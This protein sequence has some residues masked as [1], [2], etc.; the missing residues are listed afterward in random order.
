MGLENSGKKIEKQYIVTDYPYPHLNSS[1]QV[2]LSCI[3]VGCL[4]YF[5]ITLSNPP[6]YCSHLIM[7]TNNMDEGKNDF[8]QH[9]EELYIDHL[10][11]EGLSMHG[12]SCGYDNESFPLPSVAVHSGRSFQPSIVH[13][14]SSPSQQFPSSSIGIASGAV[15]GNIVDMIHSQ[16]QDIDGNIQH[17]VGGLLFEHIKHYPQR[18]NLLRATSGE[19]DRSGSNAGAGVGTGGTSTPTVSNITFSNPGSRSS[20][21][22]STPTGIMRQR[23]GSL[24][25]SA[26]GMVVGHGTSN[27][28]PSPTQRGV[29][30]NHIGSYFYNVG[31]HPNTNLVGMSQLTAHDAFPNT[32][33]YPVNTL[34]NNGPSSGS[35]NGNSSKRP[36]SPDVSEVTLFT[37]AKQS[38]E[39]S[40]ANQRDMVHNRKGVSPTRQYPSSG[41]GNNI[42]KRNSSPTKRTSTTPTTSSRYAAGAGATP[43]PATG[44]NGARRVTS[45]TRANSSPSKVVRATNTPPANSTNGKQFLK[46]PVVAGSSPT[47][48]SAKRSTNHRVSP[49]LL[50]PD[51]IISPVAKRGAIKVAMHSS[52]TVGATTHHTPVSKRNILNSAVGGRDLSFG[53]NGSMLGPF[54][55]MTRELTDEQYKKFNQADLETLHRQLKLLKLQLKS[56]ISCDR[57]ENE[58]M[59]KKLWLLVTTKE[60]EAYV[61]NI[62]ER[63]MEEFIRVH[64]RLLEIVSF[65]RF[66]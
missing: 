9:Q 27:T 13:Q 23:P 48:P 1:P 42:S 32:A 30:G 61:A 24:N 49:R 50:S 12:K 37:D 52:P 29:D 15:G 8:Q 64:Q 35:R 5:L 34:N 60:D 45:P 56:K 22:P 38:A 33:F 26:T 62:Q 20:S 11:T 39:N 16:E 40:P 4:D 53:R 46:T 7:T 10:L 3:G 63:T 28:L 58:S 6:C 47:G 59:I 31:N 21:R 19:R 41:P 54:N 25:M 57:V 43:S 36:V 17:L 55:L 2:V 44:P 65:Q 14:Q 66:L 18:E 51:K